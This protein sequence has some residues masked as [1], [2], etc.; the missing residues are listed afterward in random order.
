MAVTNSL[1][2]TIP[3]AVGRG[4]LVGARTLTWRT[5][6]ERAACATTSAK[7]ATPG[8]PLDVEEESAD[9]IA[10]QR[11]SVEKETLGEINP[12][13]TKKVA[14]L[15]TRAFLHRPISV[16]TREKD[17]FTLDFRYRHHE[18]YVRRAA[19]RTNK[20]KCPSQ[21]NAEYPPCDRPHVQMPRNVTASTQYPR[22]EH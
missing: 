5:H 8:P 21:N 11:S 6:T 2:T 20:K 22:C 13:T 14:L 17:L 9:F 16:G 4:G 1:S 19:N 10:L 7:S 12:E 15:D 18:G 3:Q